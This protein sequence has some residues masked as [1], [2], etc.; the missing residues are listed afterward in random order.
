MHFFTLN[1][2]P[3]FIMR[4]VIG[5]VREIQD[6]E[7]NIRTGKISA[8]EFRE[9][10][11]RLEKSGEFF[12]FFHGTLYS[13]IHFPFKMALYTIWLPLAGLLAVTTFARSSIIEVFLLFVLLRVILGVYDVG[14]LLR[15]RREGYIP[16]TAG[17]ISTLASSRTRTGTPPRMP[18][19]TA[20]R[21]F[22][23]CARPSTRTTDSRPRSTT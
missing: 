14:L 10:R 20:S 16:Y 23:P 22:F 17:V 8:E 19:T 15:A 3:G 4:G 13:L 7:T 12:G 21:S 5:A 1:A 18:T 11:A 9:H 2:W 6:L